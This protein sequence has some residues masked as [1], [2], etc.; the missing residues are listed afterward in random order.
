MQDVQRVRESER[1]GDKMP[2]F[3]LSVPKD[4]FILTPIEE[5]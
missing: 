5:L 4:A 3:A 1:I 2:V